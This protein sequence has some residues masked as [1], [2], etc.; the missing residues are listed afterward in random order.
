MSRRVEASRGRPEVPSTRSTLPGTFSEGPD[1]CDVKRCTWMG[2]TVASADEGVE[3]TCSA[4]RS[5]SRSSGSWLDPSD[6]LRWKAVFSSAQPSQADTPIPAPHAHL[7]WSARRGRTAIGR[8]VRVADGCQGASGRAAARERTAG[9]EK[10]LALG[11][12]TSGDIIV[13]PSHSGARRASMMEGLVPSNGGSDTM[14]GGDVAR[15]TSQCASEP[16]AV[17]P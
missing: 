14:S 12:L 15:E 3:S 4:I 16:Q 10:S 1:A 5:A 13:L 7:R 2:V 8:G 11:P 9:F 17:M 6:S